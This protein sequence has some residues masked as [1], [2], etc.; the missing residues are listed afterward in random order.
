MKP[1]T[2]VIFRKQVGEKMNAYSL[3]DDELISTLPEYIILKTVKVFDR[4]YTKEE[5]EKMVEGHLIAEPI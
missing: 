5:F 1:K 4:L 2:L 3:I